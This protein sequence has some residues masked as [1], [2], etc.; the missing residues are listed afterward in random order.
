[1]ALINF[2]NAFRNLLS[3]SENLLIL[4]NIQTWKSSTAQAGTG[5]YFSDFFGMPLS[6]VGWGIC[7]FFLFYTGQS[8]DCWLN[9][10]SF[11]SMFFNSS[12]SD[13]KFQCYGVWNIDS[14]VKQTTQKE[15][16]QIQNVSQFVGNL[17]L[18]Y[19][20]TNLCVVLFR[21]CRNAIRF[22][23]VFPVVLRNCQNI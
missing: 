6:I 23:K 5:R 20:C 15:S 9:L 16:R 12:F 13:K 17:F 10:R 1:M 2:Q 18:T 8:P 3:T 14:V 21:P 7:W 11:Q 4:P 19:F 22:S